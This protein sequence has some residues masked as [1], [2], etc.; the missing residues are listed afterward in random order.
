MAATIPFPRRAPERHVYVLRHAK[1]SWDDPFLSDAERPLSARGRAAVGTLRKHFES[2]GLSVQVVLCSPS[3]RTRETWAGVADAVGGDPEVRF[4]GVVYG[5]TT[6]TLI[7]LL[8]TMREDVTSVLLVAHNPG[9]EDLVGTLTG[10]PLPGGMPTG[11]F[12]TLTLGVGWLE[13]GPGTANLA[14][15]QRPRDLLK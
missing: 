7:N 6:S 1:S 8:R 10:A 2:I 11:A 4:V 9:C 3:R 15:V 13:L 14:S 5:G 12:A